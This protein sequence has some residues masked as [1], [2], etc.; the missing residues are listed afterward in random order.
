MM[1]E[2]DRQVK[3]L[4]TMKLSEE[5]GPALYLSGMP[6]FQG[7]KFSFRINILH[8]P[9]NE[10]Y[11]ELKDTIHFKVDVITR[12]LVLRLMIHVDYHFMSKEGHYKIQQQSVLTKG[13]LCEQIVN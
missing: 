3:D 1:R 2:E 7:I 5:A 4:V 11:L 10:I 12:L 8:C 6:H 13:F 9:E